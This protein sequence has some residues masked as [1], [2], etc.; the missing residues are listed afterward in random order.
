[1][2]AELLNWALSRKF[3]EKRV[4]ALRRFIGD[5][6]YLNITSATAKLFADKM[7]RR[8][9]TLDS[10]DK[11][12]ASLAMQHGLVI[13]TCDSDFLRYDFLRDHLVYLATDDY[14]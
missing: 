6:A 3:G 14:F 4:N 11:W 9:E 7:W 12:I 8:K 13:L 2:E 5:M 10:N 1:M